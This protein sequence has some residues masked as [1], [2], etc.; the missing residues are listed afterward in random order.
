MSKSHLSPTSSP[1]C[2]C[3]I[4]Y[5][6]LENC[7]KNFIEYNWSL[8]NRKESCKQSACP[9]GWIL[10]RS[11]KNLLDYRWPT[12]PGSPLK[13]FSVLRSDEGGAGKAET[14]DW[15]SGMEVRCWLHKSRPPQETLPPLAV[16]P[17]TSNKYK[18]FRPP[19]P[20]DTCYISY[21]IKLY[22]YLFLI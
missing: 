6:R 21:S 5:A 13:A 14:R 10:S 18:Q 19:A 11:S 12:L 1:Q 2:V 20:L 15:L 16:T 3:T 8:M 4:I 9:L 7:C 17:F 22:N